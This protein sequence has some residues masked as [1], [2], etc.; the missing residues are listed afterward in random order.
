MMR[1]RRLWIMIAVLS[2]LKDSY[3]VKK[4]LWELIRGDSPEIDEKIRKN[5]QNS[6]RVMYI[7]GFAQ[8]SIR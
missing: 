3:T 7:I 1:K 6:G 5:Q 8:T 2:A 4:G